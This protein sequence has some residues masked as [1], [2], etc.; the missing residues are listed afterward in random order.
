MKRLKLAVTSFEIDLT[1]RGTIQL[2]PYGRFR[3][4]D[5]RPT[6][7]EAWY[8]TDSNGADVVALANSQHNKLPIDYEHQIIYSR[9][10]GK[11]APSAG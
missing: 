3:A 5:G 10:N 6:D 7:V 8:V 4:T 9:A 1:K 2:L 11:E